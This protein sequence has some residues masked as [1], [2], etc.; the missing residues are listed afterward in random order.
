MD[1]N[2]IKLWVDIG[3]AISFLAVALTGISKF[4]G[5]SVKFSWLFNIINFRL[6]SRIHDWSGIL[7]ALFVLIHLILNWAWIKS[8]LSCTFGKTKSCDVENGKGK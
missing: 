5:L 3:M 1:R 7:M 4:P 2:K 8:M 6:I